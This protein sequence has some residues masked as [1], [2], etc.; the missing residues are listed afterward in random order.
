MCRCGLLSS[1]AGWIR[2]VR[3]EVGR[4]S[5]DVSMLMSEGPDDNWWSEGRWTG[6]P[7]NLRQK[8]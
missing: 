2:P 1:G 5:D 6:F 7:F 3:E 8:S 4:F